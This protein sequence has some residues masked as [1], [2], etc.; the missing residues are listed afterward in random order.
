MSDH[1]YSCMKRT[2]CWLAHVELKHGYRNTRTCFFKAI[3]RMRILRLDCGYCK[4]YVFIIIFTYKKLYCKLFT[5]ESQTYIFIVVNN[6]RQTNHELL[7]QRALPHQNLF[8]N[9]L[10]VVS[11]GICSWSINW[12]SSTKIW[13]ET[14]FYSKANF[15]SFTKELISR[16]N[17]CWIHEK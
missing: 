5:L 10:N 15:C 17:V 9:E 1:F 7:C 3:V 13:L 11:V 4:L 8:L 6:V 2:L 14:Y 16:E 12:Q